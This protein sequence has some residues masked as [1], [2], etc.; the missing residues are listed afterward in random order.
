MILKI[1]F[2]PFWVIQALTKKFKSLF[3]SNK[4]NKKLSFACNINV[5]RTERVAIIAHNL[6]WQINVEE[7]L[8]LANQYPESLLKV[9]EI[10]GPH[11]QRVWEKERI[12]DDD[13]MGCRN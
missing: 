7:T 13:K 3:Y 2:Y 11:G 9:V 1:I 10:K 4:Y 8:I 5:L 6:L 12:Q